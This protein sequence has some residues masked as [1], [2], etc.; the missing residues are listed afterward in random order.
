MRR[1]PVTRFGHR[2]VPHSAT[3]SGQRRGDV[4]MA[5]L[6]LVGIAAGLLSGGVAALLGGGASA[7]LAAYSAGGS[8]SLGLCGVICGVCRSGPTFRG[9]GRAG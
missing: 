5:G 2:A 7:A 1:L 9:S 8:V 6:I 4:S 3:R